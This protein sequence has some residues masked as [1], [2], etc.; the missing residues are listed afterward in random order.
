MSLSNVNRHGLRSP[1]DQIS[2]SPPPVAN[3]LSA[4]MPYAFPPDGLLGSMRRIF[5][6][7]VFEVLPV[8]LRVAAAA[9]VA[10]AD[11][12]VAVG[13]ERELAAVV[14]RERLLLEQDR[15]L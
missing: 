3:G 14:V 15:S 1:Y 13:P 2:G 11:V 7:N 4:G 6:R 8:A 9:A 5:P 10:E 12:Q